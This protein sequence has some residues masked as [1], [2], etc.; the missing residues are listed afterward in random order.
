MEPAG[1]MHAFEHL[2]R[3]GELG[4]V[5]ALAQGAQCLAIALAAVGG[6]EHLGKGQ[7]VFKQRMGQ[8]PHGLFAVM[9]QQLQIARPSV[10]HHAPLVLVVLGLLPAADGRAVAKQAH[11]Q[12]HVRKISLFRRNA[13]IQAWVE[14]KQPDFQ[15]FHAIGLQRLG[16]PLALFA[17]ALGP[18][19]RVKLIFNLQQVGIELPPVPA[20]ANADGLIKRVGGADG[21]LQ[22]LGVVGQR[23]E[24]DLQVGLRT[25][26]VA[27]VTHAQA[28]GIGAVQR[29]RQQFQQVSLLPLQERCAQ[30][31]RGAKQVG[32]QPAVT[33]KIAR[34][35]KV[36]FADKVEPGFHWRAQVLQ[37]G[38][39]L[40]RQRPVVVG[41]CDGLHP[42]AIAQPQALA[43]G[44][45]EAR[46]MRVSVVG[47]LNVG[48]VA[49]GAGHGA[50]PHQ[51]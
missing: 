46:S 23:V 9:R 50:G 26:L 27:Q 29:A 37:A 28:G 49:D 45:L 33:Q 18:Y 19:T 32:N 8:G 48:I 6:V 51:F 42:A 12:Q 44:L 15:V 22:S 30:G 10:V 4:M 17:N 7:Q 25:V 43:V 14:I 40:G 34:Q 1:L 21:G 2:G 31:R 5:D 36:A 13:N 16:R 38:P 39:K 20:V 35:G 11:Q 3:R 24:A 41:P 47:Q